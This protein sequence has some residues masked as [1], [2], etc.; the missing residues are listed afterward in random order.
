MSITQ[1]ITPVPTPVPNR[2]AQTQSEFDI[3]SDNLFSWLE[4]LPTELGVWADQVNATGIDGNLAVTVL[5]AA[6]FKGV[7][8]AQSGAATV[9]YAVFHEGLF[10]VLLNDVTNVAASEPAPDNDDWQPLAVEMRIGSTAGLPV[11][12]GGSG[13]LETGSFGTSAGTFCQGNDS[14]L[15]DAR[16][17]LATGDHTWTGHQTFTELSE[18][19]YTLSGTTPALDP[20]NGTLQMWSLTGNS[21]PTD[22]LTSGQFL[23]LLIDDGAAR[24]VTWPTM[25]WI[26]GVAPTLSTTTLSVIMLFKVETT[27]YGV[28]A[29]VL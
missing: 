13:V 11:V 24:L 22:A 23:L 12:T 5:A 16:A 17:P 27:L 15:S 8:S 1:T 7:W 9:P 26:G 29:G 10:W 18:T 4:A 14:R 28:S 25:A 6:N 3:A 19:V 20:G 2:T 21:A